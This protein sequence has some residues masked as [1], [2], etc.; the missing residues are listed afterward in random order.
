MFNRVGS[1]AFLL[2]MSS[3][4][5]LKPNAR[6]LASSKSGLALGFDLESSAKLVLHELVSH[7]SPASRGDLGATARLSGSEADSVFRYLDASGLTVSSD[8]GVALSGFGKDALS[9]FTLV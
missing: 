9:V 6:L 7:D 3:G 5:S 8:A 1:I 2:T 4:G